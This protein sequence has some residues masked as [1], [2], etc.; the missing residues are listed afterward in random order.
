MYGRGRGWSGGRGAWVPRGRGRGLVQFGGR[1]H[2]DN[3][4]KTVEVKGFDLSELEEI[5]AHFLVKN[6]LSILLFFV[7]LI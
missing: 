7:R 4:P 5:K 1:T 3:R 6:I 2:L